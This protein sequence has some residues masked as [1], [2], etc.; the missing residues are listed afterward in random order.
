[1]I[2]INRISLSISGLVGMSTLSAQKDLVL[3][4]HPNIVIISCEDISP[5]L[6][7]YG[8]PVVKTPNLDRLAKDGILYEN[9]FSTAGVSA[10]SRCCL[11]T[12]M[13]ATSIGGGCMRTSQKGLNDVLPYESVPPPEVKCYSEWMRKA[14]YYCTNN[15]KTDYQFKSPLSAWDACSK[16]ASWEDRPGNSP[17]FAIFNIMTTHESQID[18]RRNSPVSYYDDDVYVPPYYP[19][20]PVIRRDI[21]RNYSNITVMDRE[22][23]EII[24]KLKQQGLYDD[25]MI[26]FYSDHGGPLPRQKREIVES[27][28]HVPFIVKLPKGQK[29]G[30]H[31]SELVSFVDL[32]PTI[33][34]L[35]NIPVPRYMQGQVFL[36]AKKAS[37]RM[38]VHAARDRMDTEYDM[39][40]MTRDKDFLYIRNYHPEKPYYQDIKFRVNSIPTMRRLLELKSENKL[41]SIQMIWFA[42]TKPSEQLYLIGNDPHTLYDVANKPEYQKDLM[43]LRHEN[44]RWMKVIGDQGL[45]KEG[46]LKTEKELVWQ[47]WP[48]GI[49][50]QVAQPEISL[51]NGYASFKCSTQGSSMV[52]QI[53]GKGLNSKHWILYD[54]QPIRLNKG[55]SVTIQ[56]NRIGYISSKYNSGLL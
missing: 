49:Q 35:A 43:R 31:N 13:Y 3:P 30:T 15:D 39:V 17:F 11:I 38:Y 33:L 2:K 26:L 14:G 4:K 5:D 45:K 28:T 10:P 18:F 21:V 7:C 20:D 27:G 25:A 23:G 54:G 24:D 47:M 53:N 55:D 51:K 36:G 32:P 37:P 46:S 50:P 29:A 40:R 16:E 42:E 41:D 44:N 9:V 56:A 22:V 6:G 52:Y 1:M 8:N 34:A 19:N 12:G 48:G